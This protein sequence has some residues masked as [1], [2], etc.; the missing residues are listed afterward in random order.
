MKRFLCFIFLLVLVPS[1]CFASTGLLSAYKCVINGAYYNDYHNAGFDFDMMSID[2]YFMDDRETV[3]YQRSEWSG[4]SFESTGLARG[5]A[6]YNDDKSYTVS[7]SNGFSFM[8]FRE[9][10]DM[11]ITM[12]GYSFR[13]KLCEEFNITTDF[14][15]E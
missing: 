4:D 10:S 11:W 5:H 14:K 12:S 2:V 7:F 9:G 15:V 8:M 3:Y 13:M 1:C 6:E